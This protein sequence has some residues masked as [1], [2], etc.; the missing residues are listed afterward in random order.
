MR[1]NWQN[2]ARIQSIGFGIHCKHIA[3]DSENVVKEVFE[4][5]FIIWMFRLR[6]W[7]PYGRRK[8]KRGFPPINNNICTL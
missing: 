2:L 4:F 1:Q 3:N 6:F 7:L 5:S 8:K